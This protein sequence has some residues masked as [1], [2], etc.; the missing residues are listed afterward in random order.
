[1]ILCYRIYWASLCVV[2]FLYSLYLIEPVW[3]RVERVST[4]HAKM[5]IEMRFFCL[6]YKNAL[7]FL[8]KSEIHRV[9]RLELKVHMRNGIHNKTDI[10][11]MIFE[12]SSSRWREHL[13]AYFHHMSIVRHPFIISFR[14]KLP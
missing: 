5:K 13:F 7:Q 9:H 2:T 4:S 6:F 12:R 14:P 1:M 3:T 8:L 10:V 11:Y